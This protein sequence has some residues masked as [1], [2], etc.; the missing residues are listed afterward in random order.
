MLATIRTQIFLYSFII[1]KL[2]STRFS[3]DT[4]AIDDT[5]PMI[6]RRLPSQSGLFNYPSIPIADISTLK[7]SPQLRLQRLFSTTTRACDGEERPEPQDQSPQE[8]T[9]DR[10]ADDSIQ[11]DVENETIAEP[12]AIQP[13][14]LEESRDHTAIPLRKMLGRLDKLT[15]DQLLSRTS[16][17]RLAHLDQRSAA[18]MVSVSNKSVTKRTAIAVGWISLLPTTIDAI[19]SHSLEKGD[20]LSVARVAAIQAVKRTSDTIPLCHPGLSIEGIKVDMR[21]VKLGSGF[22]ALN[23]Q[24]DDLSQWMNRSPVGTS[25]LKMSVTVESSGKTGV[26]ME[27]L[28][29]VT[30]GLLTVYDMCKSTYKGSR[31]S[32][33]LWSKAGGKSGDWYNRLNVKENSKSS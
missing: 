8:S 25:C 12:T 31:I 30:V 32:T 24:K 16:Q 29:G 6:T 18:H 4:H 3:A 7:V 11:R 20:V 14:N 19:V 1:F 17:V 15:G 21:L 13:A 2:Y 9:S 23:L 22:P 28:H 27:A 5:T 26:E 33:R 10:L